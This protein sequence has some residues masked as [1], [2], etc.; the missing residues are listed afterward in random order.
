MNELEAYE[1]VHR[2]NS[3]KLAALLPLLVYLVVVYC[4]LL[5]LC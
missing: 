4:Q 1:D 5:R 2:G 3:G